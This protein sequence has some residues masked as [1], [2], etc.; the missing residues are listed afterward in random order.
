MQ[1][2]LALTLPVEFGADPDEVGRLTAMAM[3]VG[4]LLA[5]IGP[6]AVG[7]LRDVTGGFQVPVAVLAALVLLL[8]LPALQLRSMDAKATA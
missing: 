5:S 3:T 2:T 7:G 1:F 6:V 4:Y 8:T